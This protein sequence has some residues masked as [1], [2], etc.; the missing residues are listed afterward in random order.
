MKGKFITFEGIEGSGK[1]TQ[2]KL[3]TLALEERGIP[4]L[5]TREPGGP[6]ISEEIR[7]ILLNSANHAML[8]ETELLLYCAS[9]AQHTGE[10]ILPALE[11]GNLVI[12]DRYFDSTIAYQG[13]ARELDMDFITELTRFATY[14][15]TPDRT[16]L[17]DLPVSAGFARI[18]ERN[19]DRLELESRDF[20][21]KVRL[22]YLSIAN[23]SRLRYVVLNGLDLPQKIHARILASVLDLLGETND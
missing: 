2:V 4:F 10:T 21:E 15:T 19:L 8:P 22:Q 12:C 20:H 18:K 7:H 13:A 23:N 17:I 9:R 14:D 5:L 3:L 11:N 1:S 6:P 16:F